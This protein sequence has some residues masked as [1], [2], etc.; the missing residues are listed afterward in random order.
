[1]LLWIRL[2]ISFALIVGVVALVANDRK[3]LVEVN[4]PLVPVAFSLML[5]SI[6]VKS[7]RWL[8]LVHESGMDVS[9]RRLLGTYLV[10]SF[11]STALPTDVG[12]DA[13][14]RCSELPSLVCVV[15]IRAAGASS[16]CT[17]SMRSVG[18]VGAWT[19]RSGGS[20][21]S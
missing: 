13:V 7:A 8:L 12:S 18:K 15:R 16:V 4:W 11:F 3:T 21:P 10:G 1:M 6:A 5:I 17:T 20:L 14:R 2:A 9:F 19:A